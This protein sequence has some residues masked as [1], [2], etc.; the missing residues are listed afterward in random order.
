MTVSPIRAIKSRHVHLP[1]GLDHKPRQMISRQPIPNIWRQQKPLLTT[2]LN[3]VLRHPRIQLIAADGTPLCATASWRSARRP[4]RGAGDCLVAIGI[5]GSGASGRLLLRDTIVAP[6]A[7]R[8]SRTAESGRTRAS[9]ASQA[10]PSPARKAAAPPLA[11]WL[12]PTE[13]GTRASWLRARGTAGRV[14]SVEVAS[15]RV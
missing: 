10:E 14:S 1:N 5:A 15:S 3:E 7:V 9:A 8:W 13:P 4:G 12:M 2:T 6:L 11:V